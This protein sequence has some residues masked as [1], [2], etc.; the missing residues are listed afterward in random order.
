MSLRPAVVSL[1]LGDA[2]VRALVGRKVYH[3]TAPTS[4]ELPY[5]TVLGV[6]SVDL[7]Q[8]A[9][10]AGG[11][12]RDAVQV[13]CYAEDLDTL[14]RLAAAVVGRVEGYRGATAHA[15]VHG[16]EVTGSA[17]SAERSPTRSGTWVYRTSIECEATWQ[18]VA[19][20]LAE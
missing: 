17:E 11:V 18:R 15:S 12:L 13:D 19:E 2:T 9:D 14:A 4:A 16:I 6:S 10:G 20:A 1:L 3:M 8:S 5:V 7:A